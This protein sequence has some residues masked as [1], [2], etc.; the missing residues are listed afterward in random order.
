MTKTKITQLYE[1]LFRD[2]ELQ[3]ESNSISKQGEIFKE[4]K[5]RI[6]IMCKA[7]EDMRIES[8][9]EGIREGMKVVHLIL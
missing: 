3:G 4:S 5:A 9:Q 7:M 2:D 8:L 1:R 6:E